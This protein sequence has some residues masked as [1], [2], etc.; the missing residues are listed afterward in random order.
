LKTK[1]LSI[2]LV[3]KTLSELLPVADRCVIL[4]NGRSV[5]IGAPADLTPGLQDRYLGV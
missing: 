1:G 4:E 5:W 3:D 2:L